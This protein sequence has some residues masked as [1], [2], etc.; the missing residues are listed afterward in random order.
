M[1]I[2]SA[3]RRFYTHLYILY[4]LN[5]YILWFCKELVGW[6]GGRRAESYRTG[7]RLRIA[8]ALVLQGSY[9]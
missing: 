4:Y 7:S 8:S 9:E 1:K 3:S 6:L 5:E 2:A